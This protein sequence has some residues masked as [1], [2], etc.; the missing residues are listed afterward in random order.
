MYIPF[1]PYILFIFLRVSTYCKTTT[2]YLT[3][4]TG[5]ALYSY[6]QFPQKTL[7]QIPLGA[8]P[9]KEYHQITNSQNLHNI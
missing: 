8:T 2:E 4:E 5:N 9:V 7:L 1:I 3:K 6:L